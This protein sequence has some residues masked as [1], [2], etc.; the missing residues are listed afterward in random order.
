[1]QG[2][3][4]SLHDMLW[5]IRVFS[6]AKTAAPTRLTSFRQIEIIRD[7]NMHNLQARQCVCV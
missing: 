5:N 3:L 1:M 2:A 6:H 7:D 4:L